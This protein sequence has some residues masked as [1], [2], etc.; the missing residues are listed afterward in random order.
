MPTYRIRRSY[1]PEC[2]QPAARFRVGH[3]TQ[4]HDPGL[5][6]GFEPRPVRHCFRLAVLLP[7]WPLLLLVTCLVSCGCHV[8]PGMSRYPTAFRGLLMPVTFLL[9]ALLLDLAKEFPIVL[10]KGQLRLL[11]EPTC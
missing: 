4:P 5:L 8:P 11:R 7:F 10:Q 9:E 6:C 2:S 1:R 3:V